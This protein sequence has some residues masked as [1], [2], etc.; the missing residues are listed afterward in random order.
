MWSGIVPMARFKLPLICGGQIKHI[1]VYLYQFLDTDVACAK[2]SVR[3]RHI[4]TSIT[5]DVFDMI[6]LKEQ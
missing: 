1:H 5:V 3:M 6:N 2:L 4:I